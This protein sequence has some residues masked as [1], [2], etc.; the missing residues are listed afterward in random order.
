LNDEWIF[1]HLLSLLLCYAFKT[2]FN[3]SF[4]LMNQHEQPLLYYTQQLEEAR[5]KLTLLKAKKNTLGWLRLIS[6]LV[7]L[8]LG[9]ALLPEHMAAAV[10][11]I[12]IC[13]ACFIYVVSLDVDNSAVIEL[14][15]R[16]ISINENEIAALHHT[17]S[18]L[19]DGKRFEPEEHAYAADMDIFG[20]YSLYQYINRCESEQGCALLAQRLLEPLPVND[21]HASQEAIKELASQVKW[22][23]LFQNFGKSAHIT[24][25]TQRRIEQWLQAPE[26]IFTPSYI[27]QLLVIYPLLPVAIVILY[28]YDFITFGRF[29][30]IMILLLFLSSAFTKKINQLHSYVSRMAEEINTLHLQLQ[31]TAKEQWQSTKLR[32]IQLLVKEEN[33]NAHTELLKLKKILDR[34][35]ARLNIIVIPFLN[36]FLLWDIRQAV[37]LEQWKQSNSISVAKWFNCIAQMEVINT[38][39]TLCYNHPGWCFPVF[40]DEYFHFKA[41]ETGH[42]LIPP[43]KRITNSCTVNGS[44]QVMLITGSNMA[45][46]STFL[47]S[48]GVNTVL[49]MT[50]APVCAKQFEITPVNLI[51]SMRIADNLAENTSTF[52]AEL[53]KLQKIIEKVNKHE[54]IFILLD[55]I[56]RGTNSLDRHT[57]SVALLKQMV[58]EKSVAVIATHDIAL[59]QLEEQ[60]PLAVHNYHFD[61]Q[62]KGEDLFFDYRLKEGVCKSMNASILM[63]KIGIHMDDVRNDA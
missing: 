38:F 61:V 23:Q 4:G 6:I 54:K 59:S 20:K 52:Y 13:I 28:A 7:P 58:Q 14:T 55:E 53:K 48:L 26:K 27:K 34:F 11:C 46:K 5:Q 25:Q 60:Y 10:T 16:H 33:K 22:R 37:S 39:A 32:E 49:S 21:I 36:T 1:L 44:G 42:P 57:G 2:C 40:A 51:S 47:R 43:G 12:I 8:I 24:S 15:E 3:L 35:D 30:F 63:K 45:G 62:V 19:D 31:H 41:I 29:S 18:N 56:L 50:G 17:Y 9:F